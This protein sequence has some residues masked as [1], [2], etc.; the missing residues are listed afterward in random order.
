MIL[1]N[2]LAVV[3]QEHSTSDHLLFREDLNCI[4][5]IILCTAYPTNQGWLLLRGG[6]ADIGG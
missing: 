3:V 1:E 2:L 6:L 5:D 4:I